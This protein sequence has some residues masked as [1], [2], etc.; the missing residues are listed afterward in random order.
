MTRKLLI[1]A[2]LIFALPFPLPAAR[3]LCSLPRG[4]PSAFLLSGGT[5]AMMDYEKARAQAALRKLESEYRIDGSGAGT[6]K[7][8]GQAALARQAYQARAEAL[9]KHCISLLNIRLVSVRADINPSSSALAEVAYVYAA[10]NSSDRIITDVSYRPLMSGKPLSTTS[11]FVLEFMDPATMKSGLGPGETLTN[12][13]HDPEKFS[14]FLSEVSPEEARAMQSGFDRKFSIEVV[15]MHFTDR[16]DYKGQFKPQ[17][18]EE[19]FA[20][21]LAPLGRTVKQAEARAKALDESESRVLREFR[22]RKDALTAQEF[23]ALEGLKKSAVRSSAT[24]DRKGRC[25][26]TDVAPGT[27]FLYAGN[28]SGRAVFEKIT[29]G[30]ER[31]LRKTVTGMKKDP[32]VP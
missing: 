5:L 14:F 7:G 3:L 1:V 24:P 30:S 20:P 23:R 27:Y 8:S 10:K 29:V 15:D 12:Q 6:K 4:L 21:A 28:G 2:L 31:K 16:K 19:A 18:F 13:G 17:T 9:R 22:A 25:V 11:T 32:F 26:F